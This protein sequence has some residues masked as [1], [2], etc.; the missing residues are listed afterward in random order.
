MVGELDSPQLC[1]LKVVSHLRIYILIPVREDVL[2]I[3]AVTILKYKY[4]Y[5]IQILL[6]Y[7]EKY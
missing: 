1:I 7:I 5:F 4:Q 3:I 2:Q 6:K